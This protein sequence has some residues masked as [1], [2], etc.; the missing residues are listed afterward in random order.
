MKHIILILMLLGG[1]LGTSWAQVFVSSAMTDD[2]GAGTS[3]ETAKKTVS[4]GVAAAG[5]S[6][7][8][9]VMAGNY[10]TDV[11]LVIGANVIVMGGFSQSS[12]NTDTSQRKLPGVN[13]HWTDDT[14]CTIISGTGNHRIATV[15]GM[16]DG[17]VVRNGY[18]P[19]LGGGLLIDGGIAQYCIIK[20]CDAINDDDYDAKGGGAHIRNGG[21]LRNC[22]VTECR[23]DNGV[24]VSGES[25]HLINN[26]ITRNSPVGCGFVSDYDGNYY[27]TIQIGDQ[28]WMREN[29]RTTH[30]A[31]GMEITRS[32]TNSNAV[33]Y[34]YHDNWTDETIAELGLFYNWNAVM[35]GAESNNEIPSGIQGICPNGW[36]LPSYNEWRVMFNYVNDIPRYRCNDGNM[37]IAKAL[38]TKTRWNGY[39]TYECYVGNYMDKNNLTRFS[40]PPAGEYTS[41][42]SQYYGEHAIF[43]TTTAY[44]ND[45]AYCGV[46]RKAGYAELSYA[47][48]QNGYSVRCVRDEAQE[49]SNLQ[50]IPTV[51]TNNVTN[52]T[53]STASCGGEVVN[54]GGSDVTARGVCWSTSPNPTVNNSHTSDGTGVGVF[55]SAMTGLTPGLTYYVRAYATNSWGT[56]YGESKIFTLQN[57]TCPGAE[58][59]TDVDYN[60][61]NTVLIG[62][63][64]WMKENLRTTH[65]ADGTE[66]S[67]LYP[68]NTPATQTTYGLL[69]DWNTVMHGANSSATNPSYV[70]GVCPN[71]WHLPSLSEWEQ[72][73][74]YVSSQSIYRC[75]DNSDYIAKSLAAKTEW[76]NYNNWN[77]TC[78]VGW[79][80]NSNNTTGFSAMPA[81]YVETNGVTYTN[82]GVCTD[83]WSS[84]IN[85]GDYVFQGYIYY[86]STVLTLGDC[87]RNHH[88]SVRCLK[89]P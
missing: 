57:Q 66:L 67:Y 85:W 63:Q 77:N 8:V 28:C 88:L 14:W 43:W 18:S 34:Y 52:V 1:L 48:K 12:T 31:N 16:L 75:N 6:G 17:C 20:E 58:T 37:Q 55:T 53:A 10:S 76:A 84:T 41:N 64:C 69:Y 40:A 22:V 59:V 72:L 50:T 29:L 54:D 71:G 15:N 81:G 87:H 60:V 44:N 65:Y 68:N 74:T 30:Y 27:S 80:I 35:H 83:W 5:G 25:G 2:S 42:H 49:A 79:E 19:T 4:A 23:G 26:T 89:N 9:F 39:Y 33:P 46:V 82:F 24:G 56:A 45:N 62:S 32:L 47:T 3:W 78:C 61:Y 7:T 13:S 11:E 73:K 51:T 86:N 38:A 70:Q 36:H 21:I